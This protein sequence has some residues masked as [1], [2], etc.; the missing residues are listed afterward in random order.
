MEPPTVLLCLDEAVDGYRAGWQTVDVG[1]RPRYLGD[2]VELAECVATGA[3]PRVS[4]EHDLIVHETLLRACGVPVGARAK[5]A[6]A[7]LAE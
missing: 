7:V 5:G 2:M 3:A 4:R 1:D 6:A